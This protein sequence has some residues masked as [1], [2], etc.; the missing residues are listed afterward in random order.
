MVNIEN[1]GAN[2]TNWY[3]PLSNI[4]CEW[5]ATM[6]DTLETTISD[7]TNDP[8]NYAYY[9]APGEV[10]TILMNNEVYTLSVNGVRFVD[11][12]RSIIEGDDIFA[13]VECSDCQQPANV[14]CQ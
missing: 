7:I 4:W 13:N 14:N 9:I 10:H 12:L 8:K 5:H 2:Y 1:P 11:W 3:N 6:L